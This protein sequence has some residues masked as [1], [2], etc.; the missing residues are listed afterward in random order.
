MTAP[1]LLATTELVAVAWIAG[2]QGF[3]ASG[4]G[5]Q[6]PDD[7]TSWADGGYVVLPVTVGGTPQANAPIFQPVVQVECWATVPGSDKLPWLMA[8][9]LAEQISMATYDRS[10][11]FNRPLTLPD[12]YPV[13][14]VKS[15]RLLTHPRRVWSDV[16]DYAGYVFDLY[17]MWI[18]AGENLP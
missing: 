17:L 15:A 3:T 16:G 1:R 8:A 10:G 12:G 2:I 13:A 14:W 18:A 5:T 4:V 6:L 9:N 7:E 11:A